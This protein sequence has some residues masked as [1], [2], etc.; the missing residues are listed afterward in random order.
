MAGGCIVYQC[1]VVAGPGVYLARSLY[2]Y[3]E[4]RVYQDE[5]TCWQQG[6]LMRDAPPQPSPVQEGGLSLYPNPTNE[7]VT[8]HSR[9]KDLVKLRLLDLG[10]T[11]LLEVNVDVEPTRER[12]LHL[13]DYSAGLY[14]LKVELEGGEVL[15]KKITIVR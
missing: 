3:M 11:L 1:P 8:V 13:G 12:V 10:G 9:D 4:H 15:T 2:A 14:L 6:V 7:L 5:A